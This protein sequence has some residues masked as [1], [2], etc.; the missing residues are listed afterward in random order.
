MPYEITVRAPAPTD[1]AAWRHLFNGYCAFYGVTATDE[2]MALVWN[3]IHD[4]GFPTQ[5]LLALDSSGHPVGLAHYRTWQWPLRGST[6]CYLDDLFV[7][8]RHRTQGVAARLLASLQDLAAAENWEII[9]WITRQDNTTAR[10][11]Y[12]QVATATP[13]VTYDMAIPGIR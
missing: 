9:R 12:D 7:D 3:W 8:P 10:R 6:G 4:P 5:C 1:L 2:H 13:L 11:L